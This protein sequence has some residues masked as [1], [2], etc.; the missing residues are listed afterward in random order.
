MAPLGVVHALNDATIVWS[1]QGQPSYA[2]FN[3][4]R[5]V[6]GANIRQDQ[7]KDA[8]FFGL[9]PNLDFAGGI[10]F[11]GL[12]VVLDE[13]V[14]GL[15]NG[16]GNL[17]IP[18]ATTG[19]YN[20]SILWSSSW[21]PWDG[22]PLETGSSWEISLCAVDPNV[23]VKTCGSGVNQTVDVTP[24]RMQIF[25]PSP[26]TVY[27]WENRRVGSGTL[28]AS[29]SA[30]AGANGVITVPGV[31]V[32]PA[33][34]H[35]RIWDA[36]GSPPPTPTFTR[37]PTLTSTP[38]PTF[39]PSPTLTQ[40]PT[41]TPSPT[42][43][44]LPTFTPSPTA[45]PTFTRT[46]TPMP[47]ASPT[48]TFTAI[49][50]TNTPSPVPPTF[51]NTPVAATATPT[52]T[53]TPSPTSPPPA[54][55]TPTSLPPTSTPLP[56]TPT[57]TLPPPTPGAGDTGWVS[58]SQDNP[59]AFGDRN[60]FQINP[61]NAYADDGLY[62]EDINSGANS[63]NTCHFKKEDTHLFYTYGISVPSAATVTGIEVRLDAWADS[64]AAN[65]RMCVQLSWNNGSSWSEAQAVNLTSTTENTYILGGPN[66]TWDHS[67]TPA[68]LA[69]G[70]FRVRI[71]MDAAA[72]NRDFYLDWVPV[73][74][75]YQ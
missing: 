62:A 1:T 49:S 38:M 66:T 53:F 5:Q 56:N 73:R 71:V 15:S 67:W 40:M 75:H 64:T 58:P 2:A 26:G 23:A 19:K 24:R 48:P 25:Q 22:P 4:S 14:P 65:P 50:P 10:P 29:G 74:V 52:G 20:H 18:P 63:Q 59:G 16:S 69:D 30:T 41:F 61:T 54:T 7:H 31:L 37:T 44:S 55:I 34:V 45:I 35:L 68:D 11:A 72:N 36:G 57:S 32:E 3:A 8:S 9:P 51:T 46:P 43:I 27:S 13:T 21:N 70:K 60:G 47:S 17:A 12:S 42:S 6:W 28:L 33:G 39:T